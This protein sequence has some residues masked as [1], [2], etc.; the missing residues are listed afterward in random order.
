[1]LPKALRIIGIALVCVGLVVALL[2]WRGDASIPLGAATV[3]MAV[4]VLQ[5]AYARILA[6]NAA[7][8]AEKQS[9]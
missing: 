4:G 2:K 3:P 9:Q 6:R 5:I 1:M 7:R 8:N